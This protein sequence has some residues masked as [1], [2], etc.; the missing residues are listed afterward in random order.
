[1]CLVKKPKVAAAP[2]DKDPAIITNPYLDG[3]PAIER[4]RTGGVRSLTIPR[5]ASGSASVAPTTPRSPTISAPATGGGSA[6]T[7]VGQAARHDRIARQKSPFES[8]I[9]PHENRSSA[10]QRAVC[11]PFDRLGERSHRI[12]RDDPRSDPA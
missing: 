12:A 7:P 2:T 3:L 5:G 11:C 4:A 9:I 6:T 10:F 1:M 8:E